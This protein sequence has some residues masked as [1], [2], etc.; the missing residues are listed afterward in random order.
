MFTLTKSE[1]ERIHQ[2]VQNLDMK[3][4]TGTYAWHHLPLPNHNHRV[5]TEIQNSYRNQTSAIRYP[6]LRVIRLNESN[7]HIM[8]TV[9]PRQSQN[10]TET[11]WGVAKN[12][13]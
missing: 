10:G 2:E 1:V 13:H 12:F 8:L 5:N 11:Y 9:L 4:Q 6:E 3:S 7:T